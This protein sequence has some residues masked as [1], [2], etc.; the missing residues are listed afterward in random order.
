MCYLCVYVYVYVYVNVYVYMNMCNYMYMYK[1]MYIF[2]LMYIYICIDKVYLYIH[3]RVHTKVVLT[4]STL[5]AGSR[6][7]PR[8]TCAP[9]TAGS[10]LGGRRLQTYHVGDHSCL[11]RIP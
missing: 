11:G 4:A 7:Q 2:T 1:C 6:A 3:T 5:E 8:M 10:S 9:P